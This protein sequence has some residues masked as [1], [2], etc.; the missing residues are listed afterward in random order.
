MKNESLKNYQNEINKS[1]QHHRPKRIQTI[2]LSQT[3]DNE[4]VVKIDFGQWG[5]V[6]HTL[7]GGL[8]SVYSLLKKYKETNRDDRKNDNSMRRIETNDA[9]LVNPSNIHTKILRSLRCGY[10]GAL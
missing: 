2:A 1:A 3:Q 7:V 9:N 10:A 6:M 8:P 5:C 4:I